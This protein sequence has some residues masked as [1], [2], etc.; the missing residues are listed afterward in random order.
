[1]TELKKRREQM[2]KNRSIVNGLINARAIQ[3][4]IQESNLKF[5]LTLNDSIGLKAKEIK[6]NDSPAF[7]PSG[8]HRHRGTITDPSDF[9][10]A[11]DQITEFFGG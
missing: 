11:N 6:V 9:V 2:K 4:K 8:L 5:A 1:M 10:D 3:A 7:E